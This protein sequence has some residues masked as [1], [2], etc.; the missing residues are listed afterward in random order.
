MI[1][2]WLTVFALLFMFSFVILVGAP[3]VPTLRRQQKIALEL[4]DLKPGQVLYDLGCGDGRLLVAAAKAGYRAV[5]YE[6]NPALAA[7][8]Y[9]RTR[10][11]GGRVKVVC[12]NFWR[13]DISGADA[14]FVFL[15]DRYMKRLDHYLSGQFKNK[16]VKV[17]SYAFK[18]P[19]RRPANAV[20]ALY[21]YNYGRLAHSR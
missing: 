19:G 4:L 5:G 1:V 17:V 14:V 11:Y 3:Y 18:V 21:L 16:R 6:I 20:N 10:R 2:V 9:L 13:A 7:I 15:I 8:A 12:G